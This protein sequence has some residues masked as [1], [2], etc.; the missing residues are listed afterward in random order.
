TRW[1]PKAGGWVLGFGCAAVAGVVLYS[2]GL[3]RGFGTEPGEPTVSE[4][5]AITDT[6][7]E[8]T[9]AIQ[10]GNEYRSLL[11][12]LGS[13]LAGGKIDLADASA[14]I[15]ATRKA[16]D[17]EWLRYLRLS[18]PGLSDQECLTANLVQHTLMRVRNTPE[19]APLKA[20]LGSEFRALYGHDLTEP[21]PLGQCLI[22]EAGERP[23][24]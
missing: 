21:R 11:W 23:T 2:V 15:A 7:T 19:A 14:Q 5:V 6:D 1:K 16:R 24:E 9:D 13:D 17:P 8:L 18:F 12:Q 22:H 20:R 3:A 10:R 4:I